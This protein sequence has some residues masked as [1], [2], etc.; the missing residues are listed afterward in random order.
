MDA[1][2]SA[3]TPLE[4]DHGPKICFNPYLE[5][6]LANGAI[7]NC[8]QC[9]GKA[10]YHSVSPSDPYDLGVLGRDGLS[11]ASRHEADPHYLD[12]AIQTDFMWTIADAL[13]SNVAPVLDLFNQDLHEL[14]LMDFAVRRR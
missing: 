2:L 12:R 6:K 11:L 4:K 8:V 10:A 7:S 5:T 14:E 3:T 1:T 13:N 9:H